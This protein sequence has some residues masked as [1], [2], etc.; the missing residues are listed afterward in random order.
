MVASAHPDSPQEALTAAEAEALADRFESVDVDSLEWRK[1]AATGPDGL[2][3]V[4]CLECLA[5]TTP[6]RARAHQ[7]WHDRLAGRDA[8]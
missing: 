3:L 2:L 4:E 6:G 7:A 8:R 5:V 1:V